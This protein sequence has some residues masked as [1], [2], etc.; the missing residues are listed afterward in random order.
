MQLQFLA[1]H[2]NSCTCGTRFCLFVCVQ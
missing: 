1:N 2:T